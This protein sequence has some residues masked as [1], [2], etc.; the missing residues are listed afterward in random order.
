MKNTP[1]LHALR[2]GQNMLPKYW[3]PALAI[4]LSGVAFCQ[5]GRAQAPTASVLRIDTVNAVVYFEDT[6]DVS[7]FTTD[8]GTPAPLLPGKNFNRQIG[9]ADIQAVNGQ[10]VMGVHTRV[11]V[12]IGL[13]TA[14]SPGQAIADGVRNAADRG[15]LRNLEKRRYADRDDHGQRIYRWRL[16]A[17]ISFESDGVQYCDYWWHGSI[18]RRSGAGGFGGSS[19]GRIYTTLSFNDGGSREP[20]PEWRWDTTVGNPFDPNGARRKLRPCLPVL[21][22]PIPMTSPSSR[23]PGRQWQERYCR[24]LRRASAQ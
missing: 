1:R 13:K 12:T 20:A 15:Q 24:C 21:P 2:R 10:P 16:A 19:A 5:P 14:P 9:I 8:P 6:G 22:S 23:R 11:G 18:S 3:K 4:A 7:K 17:R